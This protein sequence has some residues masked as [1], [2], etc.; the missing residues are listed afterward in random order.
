MGR[1]MEL[2]GQKKNRRYEGPLRLRGSVNFVPEN[3]VQLLCGAWEGNA[4]DERLARAEALTGTIS[5][6]CCCTLNR[7][8]NTPS[9]C[10]SIV[11]SMLFGYEG[12]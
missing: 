4:C 10:H 8:R 11:Y 3:V 1:K 2:T 9:R 7:C 5:W 12:P 6:T